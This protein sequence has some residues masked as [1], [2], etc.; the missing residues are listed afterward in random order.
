MITHS[1]L[2]E[3]CKT[4]CF[5][6]R[7]DFSEPFWFVCSF[8]RTSFDTG[9]IQNYLISSDG[10]CPES[11]SYDDFDRWLRQNDY[12]DNSSCTRL[13]LLVKRYGI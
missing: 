10:L 4:C 13:L 3:V 5:C 8:Y 11:L 1:Q 9:F 6:C 2:P 12:F 7:S